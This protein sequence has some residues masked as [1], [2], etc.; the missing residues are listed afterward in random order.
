M[1]LSDEINPFSSGF[2][3]KH[4]IIQNYEN[5]IEELNLQ[6]KPWQAFALEVE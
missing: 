1:N 4:E 3:I 6:L 5:K 2:V